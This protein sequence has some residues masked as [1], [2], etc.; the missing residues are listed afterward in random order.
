MA[1]NGDNTEIWYVD[2][3]FLSKPDKFLISF[4]GGGNRLSLYS[5]SMPGSSTTSSQTSASTSQTASSVMSSTSTLISSSWTSLGCYN[6][7]VVSRTLPNPIY[8]QN[9][10]MT[11]ELCEIS[12]K[13]AGYTFSGVEYGGECYCDNSINNYGAPASDGCTM[14]CHGNAAQTCGGPDRVNIY[15]FITFT[16][17]TTSSQMTSPSVINSLVSS[18]SELSSTSAVSFSFSTLSA[19]SS[20]Y[21]IS[22]STQPWSSPMVT[23]SSQTL[24]NTSSTVPTAPS[25]STSSWNSTSSTASSTSVSASPVKAIGWY[26]AGCYV[27][28]VGSRTLRY[29]MQVP[30]GGG[31][32]TVEACNSICQNSKY[33]IAGVE[34]GGE[35]CMS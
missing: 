31:S 14:A 23:S 20:T 11:V 2:K 28:S 7:S 29:G 24:L 16:A 35:C 3:S 1:C 4:S 17:S 13:N 25:T 9:D 22:S 15:Q 21:N 27:D 10:V 30:G 8:G 19:V 18:G 26:A 6:D 34:Y 5:L 32:M 33:T 12:C